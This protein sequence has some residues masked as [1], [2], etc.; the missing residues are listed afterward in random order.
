MIFVD[1]LKEKAAIGS[2]KTSSICNRCISNLVVSH[3]DTQHVSKWYIPSRGVGSDNVLVRSQMEQCF[4][5]KRLI[6]CLHRS[7]SIGRM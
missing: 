4:F 6:H 1:H 2:T 3:H 7:E 5:V